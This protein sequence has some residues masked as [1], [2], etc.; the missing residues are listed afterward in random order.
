MFG[1]RKYNSEM[2]EDKQF[3]RTGDTFADA[4]SCNNAN[5]CKMLI[6]TQNAENMVRKETRDAN[7]TDIDTEIEEITGKVGKWMAST[8]NFDVAKETLACISQ[9]FDD[10]DGKSKAQ[11]DPK[12][13]KSL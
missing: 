2:P 1:R 12:V 5:L 4:M 3:G 9:T 11:V 13:S 6:G 7:I 10:T 8:Q